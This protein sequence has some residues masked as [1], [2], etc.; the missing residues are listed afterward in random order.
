LRNNSVVDISGLSNKAKHA[1]GDYN[2]DNIR[3]LSA[4]DLHKF[5][6]ACKRFIER[7]EEEVKEAVV[8]HQKEYKQWRDLKYPEFRGQ[9]YCL[10]KLKKEQGD[11]VWLTIRNS[12]EEEAEKA[13]LNDLLAEMQRE[14]NNDRRELRKCINTYKLLLFKKQHPDGCC[15]IMEKQL[16]KA[17]IVMNNWIEDAK[18][19]MS[20]D[21]ER[22]IPAPSE[23][24]FL[25]VVFR[26]EKLKMLIRETHL[27]FCG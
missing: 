23:D 14:H 10:G 22:K 1:I 24:E 7:S 16:I 26:Y 19:L 21:P 13:G 12:I 18:D 6:E 17:A 25:Q 9:N 15:E 3:Q 27:Q 4:E 20:L 8:Q 2:F 11:K 5:L